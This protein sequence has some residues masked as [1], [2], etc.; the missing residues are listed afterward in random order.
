MGR[1]RRWQGKSARLQSIMRKI[2]QKS[3]PTDHPCAANSAE[4]SHDPKRM[5]SGSRQPLPAAKLTKTPKTANL[6][7]PNGLATGREPCCAPEYPLSRTENAYGRERARKT[8]RTRRL[9]FARARAADSAHSPLA[10]SQ[11]AVAA[12]QAADSTMKLLAPATGAAGSGNWRAMGK[13]ACA[14]HAWNHNTCTRQRPEPGAQGAARSPSGSSSGLPA[15]H[16]G[17]AVSST[18]RK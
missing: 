15:T 10:R 14:A 17:P 3:F 9:A 7:Q 8:G 18:C 2:V 13:V 16:G 12:I 4:N 5:E 1:G 11:R 6:A